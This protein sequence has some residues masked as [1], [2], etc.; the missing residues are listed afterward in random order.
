MRKLSQRLVGS[1]FLLS[2]STPGLAF[3]DNAHLENRLSEL[4]SY[5]D[6]SLDL[7]AL[8]REAY[9]E[10]ARLSVEQRAWLEGQRL[11][12]QVKEAVLRGYELAL[13]S[14]GSASE[15]RTQVIQDMESEI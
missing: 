12:R 1:L 11:H 15:A 5:S 8:E 10:Q 2:L 7:D 9:Y 6:T 4:Q 13:A 3:L 14:K